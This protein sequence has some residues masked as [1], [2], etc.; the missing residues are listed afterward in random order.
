MLT[1][2]CPRTLDLFSKLG[3]CFRTAVY[4]S[5]ALDMSQFEIMSFATLKTFQ[6]KKKSVF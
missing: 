1:F 3:F 6:F 2:R 5:S 4:D